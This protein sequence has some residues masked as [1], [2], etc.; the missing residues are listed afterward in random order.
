MTSHIIKVLAVPV[1]QPRQRTRVVA[2]GGRTFT[3]NYTP[4]KH[5]VNS[6]KA[7]VQE[8]ASN[9]ITEPLSGPVVLR[10]HFILPRP[11]SKTKKT[12]PN[13]RYASESKPDLDNLEKAL[14][15]ALTGIAWRDDSQ[16]YHKTT[17]KHVAAGD[18]LP[19]VLVMIGDSVLSEVN[20]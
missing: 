11:K 2:T 18:E 9:V 20:L 16:V 12:L 8:A 10:A 5:P 15:D 19:H 4:T 1:A 6:F 13:P 17:M 7:S 3:Q 14:M